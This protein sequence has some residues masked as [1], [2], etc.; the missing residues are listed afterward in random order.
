MNRAYSSIQSFLFLKAGIL[1]GVMMIGVMLSIPLFAQSRAQQTEPSVPEADSAPKSILFPSGVPGP[2]FPS[3]S[4]IAETAENK[5]NP[6]SGQSDVNEETGQLSASG[7]DVDVIELGGQDKSAYGTL[8]RSNGGLSRII[9]QPSTYEDVEKLFKVLQLPSKS[10]AMNAI[11][12]KLLLSASLPPLGVAVNINPEDPQSA[13]EEELI[14][15]DLVKKFINLRLSKLIEQG[16]LDDMVRFIQNLPEG[17]LEPSQQ[18]AEILMLGGDIIGACEM[19]MN[20]RSEQDNQSQNSFMRQNTAADE[21]QPDDLF[22]LK[23][24]AFCRTLE[25]DNTGAQIALDMMTERGQEDFIFFDL[26][27]KL[28]ENPDTRSVVLSGGLST[29]DPLQYTILSLLDQPIDTNLIEDSSPLILSALV[30]NPN[31]SA[32]N[33]FQAAVKSYQS[34]GVSA[35]VLR[36]IFGLQEFSEREYNNAEQLAQFDDRPM[37]DALLY[38]TASRQADDAAKTEILDVIWQRAAEK[39]DLPRA[40]EL[41]IKTLLSLNPSTDLIGQAYQITR[42]LILGG[43]IEKAKEWYDFTRRAASTGNSEATTA[44]IKTW[45]LVILAANKGEIAWSEDILDL[46]WNGQALLSPENRDNKA[47]LFYAL[48]E[49]F[50]FDVPDN[51]W[52]ELVAYRHDDNTHSI[53]L[54]VWRDMIRSVAENKQGQAVILSLIAMGP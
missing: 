17:T 34:G 30:I 39:N 8:S 28:M 14:A 33:R 27:N 25:G 19:T 2:Y 11:S 48:A 5:L 4:E 24:L 7:T 41:N 49:A 1:S 32:D 18:N 9:W 35:D 15:P 47:S 13:P 10:P 20:T 21:E 23:M 51:K 43:E 46:W 45:P 3:D 6:S 36:N 52:Q 12:K 42:G 37:M 29:L 38:Q 54:A 40:S 31:M 53:P 22:W 16:N 44:L 50:Q 26:L